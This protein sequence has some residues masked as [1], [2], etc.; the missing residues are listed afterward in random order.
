MNTLKTIIIAAALLPLATSAQERYMTRNGH[1]A[2]FSATPMENIEAVHSVL[3]EIGAGGV[4]QLLAFNKADL[5][6]DEAARPAADAVPER[7]EARQRGGPGTEA[8][9]QWPTDADRQQARC[10]DMVG[11]E[12]ADRTERRQLRLGSRE[13]RE[14]RALHRVEAGE[15]EHRRRRQ[16]PLQHHADQ[17]EVDQ[18][19]GRRPDQDA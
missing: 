16:A 13:Q 15:A 2:F 5:A 3:G 19:H 12:E 17:P 10:A 6:P 11:D 4:P 9:Q 14:P 18:R 8:Q 1:I 7:E